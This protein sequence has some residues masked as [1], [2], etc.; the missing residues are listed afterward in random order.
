VPDEKKTVT[1]NLRTK[2]ENV[3]LSTESKFAFSKGHPDS[4]KRNRASL[5]LYAGA[6]TNK[7]LQP[8]EDYSAR[9]RKSSKPYKN[10]TLLK[11]KPRPQFP[12][13]S[14][15]VTLRETLKIH[16]RYRLRAQDFMVTLAEAGYKVI[17]T[18]A[19]PRL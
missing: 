7:A 3:A 13:C 9:L 17:C 16:E 18:D 14:E 5:R 19:D 12:N 15:E 11:R 6:K 1:E 8:A 2:G 10:P 4:T